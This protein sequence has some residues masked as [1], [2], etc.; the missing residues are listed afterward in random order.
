MRREVGA[1]GPSADHCDPTSIRF[2]PNETTVATAEPEAY[3]KRYGGVMPPVV[4]AAVDASSEARAEWFPAAS[5]AS[6]PSV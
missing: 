5:N 3:M 2:Q 4:H 1:G 6:T